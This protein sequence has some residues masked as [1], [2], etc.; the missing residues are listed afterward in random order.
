M[1]DFLL[2]LLT[3]SPLLFLVLLINIVLVS[4]LVIRILLHFSKKKN[5]EKVIASFLWKLKAKKKKE[6]I[7]T[8][9]D[10][11]KIIMEHLRKDGLLGK[12]EK[13]GFVS[14]KKVMEKLNEEKKKVLEHLFYLY[15]AKIYGEKEI[16]DEKE[17]ASKLL[18]AYLSV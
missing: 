18:S 9:E 13:F 12:N 16:K 1:I 7:E 15:E 4:Y 6:E 2:T 5:P 10:V 14:R 8:I 17:V 11:Y 3:E